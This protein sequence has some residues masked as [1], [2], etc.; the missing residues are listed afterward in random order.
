MVSVKEFSVVEIARHGLN[1][2]EAE[3]GGV[4]FSAKRKAKKISA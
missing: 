1:E 3:H 2:D 4:L